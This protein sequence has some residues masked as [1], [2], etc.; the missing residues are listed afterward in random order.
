MGKLIE[1]ILRE[2]EEDNRKVADELLADVLVERFRAKMQPRAE[3]P[4]DKEIR[5]LKAKLGKVCK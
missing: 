4:K 1:R 3:R 5:E 2:A